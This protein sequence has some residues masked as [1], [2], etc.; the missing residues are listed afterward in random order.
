MH[1]GDPYINN[2]NFDAAGA[3]LAWIHGPLNGGRN[4]PGG[5][6]NAF[7]QGKFLADPTRHGLAQEGWIYVPDDC[8]SG[9]GAFTRQHVAGKTEMNCRLRQR[10]RSRPQAACW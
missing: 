9:N 3:L 1:M 6:P 7:A 8:R 2:C 10:L 5:S 4:E